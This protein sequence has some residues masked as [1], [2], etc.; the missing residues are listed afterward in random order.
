MLKNKNQIVIKGARDNNLKNINLVIPRNKLIVFT[1]VSGSGKTTLAFKTIF[2][3]GQRRYLDSISNYAR[4]FIGHM[5]KA[6]V[7]AIEGLSPTIAIN[8]KT[9]NNNPRSTVGTMTELYDYL[10]LLFARIGKVYCPNCEVKIRTE[11]LDQLITMLQKEYSSKQIIIEAPVVKDKKGQF[12]KLIE[13]LKRMPFSRVSIDNEIMLIENIEELQNKKHNINLIIDRLVLEEVN[14]S[15][16]S[17]DLEKAFEIGNG[18]V[19]INCNNTKR[20]F[21]LKNTC[22]NCGYYLEKLTPS[23]FSFN[24]PKGACPNCKGLG[25]VSEIKENKIFS[26]TKKSIKQDAFKNIGWAYSNSY[27][28]TIFEELKNK[29]NLNLDGMK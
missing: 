23:M 27:I 22:V 26:N 19:V 12:K 2:A 8:Q 11:T 13:E 20:I 6:D 25:V 3:E 1:G 9:I 14:L 28:K 18:E 16:F 10:R 29:V 7:D 24:S 17:E 5:K 15:R 21:S 4:Q